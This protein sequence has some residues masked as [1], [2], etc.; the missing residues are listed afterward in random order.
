[1]PTSNTEESRKTSVRI[2]S[3]AG[4]AKLRSMTENSTVYAEFLRFQGR[5][6]KHTV[7]VALE[8]FVQKPETQFIATQ[9]QWN[10]ANCTI[11][12]GSE[13]IRFV[14]KNGNHVDYYD[15]SQV[16]ETT[17]PSIWTINAHNVQIVKT[18]LGIPSNSPLINGVIYRTMNAVRITECMKSLNVAPNEYNSFKNAF[19]NAVQLIIAGR[20]EIGGSKFD[21]T[22]DVSAMSMFQT[23]TQKLSFL[24]H[25]ANAA[26]EALR[27]IENTIQN[28]AA[29]ERNDTNDLRELDKINR[30]RT[31]KHA[32]R[33]SSGNT[34]GTVEEWLNSS[35]NDSQRERSGMGNNTESEE[36]TEYKMVSDVSKERAIRTG[37]LVQVRSD[38][39]TVQHESNGGRTVTGG[40]ADWSLRH[41]MDDF[42]GGTT[43]TSGDRDEIT[44]QISDSSSFSRQVSDGV[45]GLTGQ[46]I[47][48][49]ELSSEELRGNSSVG[50]DENVL[51]GQ[52]SD[53]G[54]SLSASDRSLEAKLNSVFS[55][56]EDTESISEQHVDTYI[57]SSQDEN[58]DDFAFKIHAAFAEVLEKRH[59]T[60]KELKYMERLETFAAR[61]QITENLID[62]AF[63]QSAAF[64]NA[65]GNRRLLSINVFSRRLGSM[66]KEL[67]AALIRQFSPVSDEMEKE[68]AIEADKTPVS[69]EQKSSERTEIRSEKTESVEKPT[70]KQNYSKKSTTSAEKLYQQ[71][72][73]MFPDIVSGTHSHERYEKSDSGYE[74]LSVE[75]LGGDTYS[76]MTYYI[77]NGDVMRDPDFTFKLDHESKKLTI[78]EYQQDGVPTIGTVYQCVHD[79]L[80]NADKKLLFALEKNFMQN[81]KNAQSAERPLTEFTNKDGERTSLKNEVTDVPEVVEDITHDSTPELREV[82]NEFSTKHSLGELNVEPQKYNWVLKETMQDGT[83]HILGEITNPEYGIPFTPEN[84]RTALDKFETT[85]NT[86]GQNV[87]DLYGRRDIVAMHGLSPLPKVQDDLPEIVYAKNPMGKIND[88]ITAIREMLR[89]EEA[90]RTGEDPYD[91]RSNQYNSKQASEQ[92][93]RK[94]CGWGGLPQVFDERLPQYDY[95]RKQLQDML[96]PE[97]YAAARESTLNAHY[98]PQIIIDS[99]YKAIKNMDLPRDSRILEPACGTGNFISRLPHSIGNAEVVGVEL[100]SITARIAKLR[101]R[102]TWLIRSWAEAWC[103]PICWT[104]LV[105][106]MDMAGPL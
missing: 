33:G 99:M 60:G 36:R 38:N 25:A 79:E 105:W 64:R 86:R 75:H 94:Y 88:N 53:E 19:V 26:R 5:V 40:P 23:D 41:E 45:Q 61:E 82:L 93:L 15:F 98:T 34:A 59:F 77:Q 80:G 96:T 1:M 97:E 73:E 85:V 4:I 16:E 74:T 68:R 65:Y 51:H 92:R 10:N 106:T 32:R 22:P 44:A 69:A 72:A 62:A 29:K 63:E 24:T 17:P 100:D 12:Q 70:E 47:R 76:F 48:G 87:S 103:S 67:N 91:K 31:D 56:S 50:T 43:S 2:L 7:N 39:R 81:L 18:G 90:E 52:Y 84:L 8:F 78:L 21:I 46:T 37:D 30:G 95:Y 42:H 55:T 57:N 66:E 27:K 13:A 28:H 58:T 89:L 35:E 11:S 54:K 83:K 9:Q 6:Y 20:L 104:R 101:L 49:D 14:D 71:F 3:E 102:P